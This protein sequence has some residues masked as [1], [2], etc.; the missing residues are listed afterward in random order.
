M[1]TVTAVARR[2]RVA[3]LALGLGLGGCSRPHATGDASIGLDASVV[4]AGALDAGATCQQ[5]G[6]PPRTTAGSRLHP[7][8]WTSPD[9]LDVPVGL[10]DTKYQLECNWFG[11]AGP[12]GTSV[13]PCRLT[14]YPSRNVTNAGT[15]PFTGTAWLDS[16]CNSDPVYLAGPGLANQVID[17]AG[18]TITLGDE[19]TPTPAVF[20]PPWR[21]ASPWAS[22]PYHAYRTATS[23][24]DLVTIARVE[25]RGITARTQAVFLEGSD[26][27]EIFTGKLVDVGQLGCGK[28]L[29]LAPALLD[30]DRW[31]PLPAKRDIC[32]YVSGPI[33]TVDG[34]VHRMDPYNGCQV[35]MEGRGYVTVAQMQPGTPI[36]NT[37]FDPAPAADI[38]G[39][40]LVIPHVPSEM[41]T[42][43]LPVP[44]TV[45]TSSWGGQRGFAFLYPVVHDTQLAIDCL[46]DVAADGVTRCLPGEVRADPILGAETIYSVQPF[47][48][49]GIAVYADATCTT[50]IIA[51]PGWV[52]YQGLLPRFSR[53]PQDTY[54]SCS[55]AVYSIGAQITA[56]ATVY[57]RLRDCG[58][59]EPIHM[60]ID[61]FYYYD[62]IEAT[63]SMFAAMSIEVR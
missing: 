31:A 23:A 55:R 63:P 61:G 8:H 5:A 13:G 12:Y 14:R 45:N 19:L 7:V 56:P 48:Q 28:P 36:A 9:G 51:V 49:S 38:G 6:G 62:A 17:S 30:V 24:N 11:T 37:D 35:W 4:D 50:R 20:C 58:T 34:T 21:G 39:S 59:C 26:G 16:T 52:P 41:D 54:G 47:L 60:N 29:V 40:R 18:G 44:A 15:L 43:I 32:K 25:R 46:P 3:A 33:A 10:F 22:Y 42:P 1:E 57:G 2:S 53:E 27:S